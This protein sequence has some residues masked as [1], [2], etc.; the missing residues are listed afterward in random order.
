MQKLIQHTVLQVLLIS[1]MSLVSWPCLAVEKP[2]YLYLGELLRTLEAMQQTESGESPA[3][4][5]ASRTNAKSDV[6]SSAISANAGDKSVAT[7]ALSSTLPFW[8]GP[9]VTTDGGLSKVEK[10]PAETPST[11]ESAATEPP[12][13][14]LPA[15]SPRTVAL[16]WLDEFAKEQ[17]LL[18][19]EDVKT[20]RATI[21][22]RPETDLVTWL[23]ATA[24][25]REAMDTDV[26][27]K[28]NQWL[29]EFWQVQAIYT[30]EQLAAFHRRMRSLT[31]R[32]ILLVMDHFANEYLTRVNRR[33]VNARR[34]QALSSVPAQT[35]STRPTS[36]FSQSAVRTTNN[37]PRRNRR[38]R[39]QNMT[40]DRIKDW[41]V[42]RGYYRFY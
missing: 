9:P 2:D 7:A 23:A 12:E 34:R 16:H 32:E 39:Y 3:A 24:P 38:E 1:C 35:I 22:A 21:L 31:P 15:E 37:M 42:F 13:T 27:R 5:S 19:K 11:T 17:T 29:S 25:L 6:D 36:G 18:A 33:E 40:S 30:D 28:T 26:W 8:L 4:Q 10:S 41:F 20:M 14:K